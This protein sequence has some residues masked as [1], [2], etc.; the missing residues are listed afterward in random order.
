MAL[1]LVTPTIIEAHAKHRRTKRLVT[2][3]CGTLVFMPMIAFLLYVAITG[4]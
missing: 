4:N 2:M 3:I 1:Y